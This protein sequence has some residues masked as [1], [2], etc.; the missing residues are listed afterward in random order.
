MVLD[1]RTELGSLGH[2]VTKFDVDLNAPSPITLPQVDRTVMAQTMA[3]IGFRIGA[4]VGVAAGDHSLIICKNI[5]GVKLY[6]IDPWKRP[7]G[8]QSFDDSKLARWH[9]EAKKKLAPYNCTL[10]QKT[11]MEAVSTFGY[12]SL[13]FVYID[14]A[15]DFKNIAMDICEWIKK[16]KP[17]GILYGHD[18]TRIVSGRYACHVKD[19]VE[20]YANSHEISPWFVLGKY[21][22]IKDG[23]FSD[24]ISSWMFIVN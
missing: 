6:C 21:E 7:E 12:R 14:G 10:I 11:S 19:V 1:Q 8:Y 2:F 22:R 24:S 16:V 23:R 4:E 15:H 20:A 13:D 3:E 5:P 18:F 9:A 17:G